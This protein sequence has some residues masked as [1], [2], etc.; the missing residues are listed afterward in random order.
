MSIYSF[1][2]LNR[3]I[4]N[5]NNNS[6]EMAVANKKTKREIF[7][8]E[9][10]HAALSVCSYRNT[11]SFCYSHAIFSCAGSCTTMMTIALR[12]QIVSK[13]KKPPF[14]SW[15]CTISIDAWLYYCMTSNDG[16]KKKGK[17][18]LTT[19]FVGNDDFWCGLLSF[20]V[21]SDETCHF[22]LYFN[23]NGIDIHALIMVLFDEREELHRFYR[24]I[25]RE[26]ERERE[27]KIK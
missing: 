18:A 27:K 15:I 17:M 24:W 20:V 6:S 5:N 8:N 22:I 2:F 13:W 19:P 9:K 23:F 12:W 7:L 3:Q 11:N 1:F 10:L 16:I 4:N 25:T 14:T 21:I 26:R